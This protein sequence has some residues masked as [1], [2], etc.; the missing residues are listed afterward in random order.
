M[1]F[2]ISLFF[3]ASMVM[4]VMTE[5][6]VTSGRRSVGSMGINDPQHLAVAMSEAV[7]WVP[8]LGCLAAV[9]LILMCISSFMDRALVRGIFTALVALGATALAVVSLLGMFGIVG[10][11]QAIITEEGLSVMM[12]TAPLEMAHKRSI[13]MLLLLSLGTTATL[14]GRR[15][16]RAT[17]SEGGPPA[18]PTS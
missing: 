12:V 13:L 10:G 18:I 6:A 3:L 2:A 14:M 5:K 1:R 16:T 11:T 7:N 9:T 8:I 17:V 4:F 15:K